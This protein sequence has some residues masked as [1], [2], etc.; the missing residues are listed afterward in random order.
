MNNLLPHYFNVL[1]PELPRVCNFHEI[2]IPTFHF[3]IIKHEFAESLI[4]YQL[5]RMLNEERGSILITAKVRTHSFLGFKLYV[6]NKM[7]ESYTN[8]CYIL[9]CYSC[10]RR[11]RRNSD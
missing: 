4:S 8:Q 9:D 10:N 7:I 3:P 2:R 6:K 5:V 1:I 11:T